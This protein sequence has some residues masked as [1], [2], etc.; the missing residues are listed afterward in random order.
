ML[1]HPSAI[2]D[3]MPDSSSSHCSHVVIEKK[4]QKKR[5]EKRETRT[6]ESG[7]LRMAVVGGGMA[8]VSAVEQHVVYSYWLVAVASTLR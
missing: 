3:G 1:P 2:T 5:E 4:I 6:A 8:G 7:R